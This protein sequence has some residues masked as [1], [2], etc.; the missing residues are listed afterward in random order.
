MSVRIRSTEEHD[1]HGN[2]VF[3]VDP[4][5]ESYEELC[6]EVAKIPHGGRAVLRWLKPEPGWVTKQ[7][8]HWDRIEETLTAMDRLPSEDEDS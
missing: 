5:I 7:R 4:S 6:A 2:P 1:E 8:A 3:D